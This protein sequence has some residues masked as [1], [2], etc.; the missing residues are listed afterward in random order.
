[1]CEG[2]YVI[3]LVRLD[4]LYRLALGVAEGELDPSRGGALALF[5]I[6]ASHLRILSSAPPAIPE[7]RIPAIVSTSA[8]LTLYLVPDG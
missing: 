8:L 2:Q 1:M 5:H 7:V 4:R 3:P 6:P